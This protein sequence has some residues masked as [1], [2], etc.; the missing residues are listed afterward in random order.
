MAGITQTI[1][2][3]GGGG[4]SEQADQ[5]KLPG[6]LKECI[7]AIPDITYGLYKRPGAKRIGTTPIDTDSQ[8][9][10]WAASTAY[11]ST[12]TV[13]S[14]SGQ[15]TYRRA[16]NPVNTGLVFEVTTAGTSGSSEPT[17]PT[18]AGSTVTDGGVTWT[19]RKE[20]SWHHYY[21]DETEGSYIIFINLRGR[22]RVWSCNDASEKNVWFNTDNNAFDG[23]DA[24]DTAIRSYLESR[25]TEDKQ[26]LTI[27]D[28]TFITNRSKTVSTTGTTPAASDAHRA[29]IDLLRTENGR[30][31]GINIYTEETNQSTVNIA[32]RVRVSQ[33]NLNEGGGTAP[34]TGIGTQVFTVSANGHAE[35]VIA[36]SSVST[37]NDTITITGHG[38]ATGDVVTY[39]SNG[40]APGTGAESGTHQRMTPLDDC[41]EYFVIRTDAN[42]I[43]LAET[44]ANATAGTAINITNDGNDEQFI[45]TMPYPDIEV[46]N[47]AGNRVTT[48]KTNLVFRLTTNGQQGMI[49][50]RGPGY[51]SEPGGHDYQCSYRREITLLHGGEGWVTGDTVRVMM[52]T[53]GGIEPESSTSSSHTR[54]FRSPAYYVVTVEEHESVTVK[55]RVGSTTGAGLIR[56]APTPFD[57]DTAVTP[58]IILGGIQGAL[59]SAVTGTIIGNGI[60]LTSSNSFNVE[61]V[62]L[63]L[64]RVMQSEINDVSK[65]PI[66]C[67]DGFITKVANTEASE[68]DDY[69]VKFV[70]ENGRDGVGT[71]EECAAPGI[72]L[73]FNAST[74][75]HI[76]QRQ[77]DGD[78]LV[79]KYEWAD[80]EVGDDVTNEAPSFV[81]TKN[82]ADPPVYSQ[83]V[84]INK[85]LF[86]RNR[87]TFLS[88]T[89]V[90]TAQPGTI[91]KPNFWA[92]TAL[93]VSARD[94]VDIAC[95]SEYP[96]ALYDGIELPVGLLCFSSNQQ[97]LLSADDTVFNPDTAKLRSISTFNYNIVNPPLDLG[98]SVGYLDNTHKYSKFNELVNV[99][100]EGLPTIQEATKVVPSLLPKQ[101]DLTTNSR[102]NG[103]VFLSQSQSDT[104][105]VFKYFNTGE[106]RE[107][108]SWFKWKHNNPI[109]YHFAIEDTYYF[110]DTDGFLQSINLVQ[111]TND[112]SIDEGGVNFLLHFDNYTTITGGVY[113]ATTKLTTFTHGTGGCVFNWQSSVTSPNGDLALVDN[114]TTA[115]RVG[116]YAKPTVTSAGSTFTVPGDWSTGTFYIG[117]LYEY[118]V[119]FPR[120]YRIM[121]D[122]ERVRS[123]LNSSLI[124]HRMKLNLGKIGLYSTKLTRKGKS[125]YE[126]TYESSDLDEYDV[127]DAPYLSEKIKTIPVYE[128]NKN[129]LVTLTS[130]H[131]AP[132]TL[133]S[134]S[135]EGDLTQQNYRRV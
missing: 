124:V 91:A 120:F 8:F 128:N 68:E 129:V 109:K 10:A 108:S 78:F 26:T 56:P 51:G 117:Y 54:R 9:T 57:S 14:E 33:D 47:A 49:N 31:Y 107:Q 75:P 41:F 96:S 83:D 5:M 101:L 34:C 127:S 82:T 100:R 37:T 84:T 22:P 44:A 111:A 135:W 61:V 132:A 30:Q 77:A 15:I 25:D 50:G 86:Y 97:F 46:R 87:L 38:L 99:A 76:M 21:R 112:P 74:M 35:H 70:G 94:P 71:W 104:V 130:S 52:D 114:N 36:Q 20:G 53:A 28:T 39:R 62:D 110:L 27:N 116:R 19:A 93:T 13:D 122:G 67:K 58:D 80:R 98:M 121:V 45:T 63:D 23:S 118:N 90:I 115:T 133:H 72:V 88:D 113:S 123:D 60:Y 89:N 125:D 40:D 43:Q 105:Y 48:G 29:Y 64:M 6:Q 69:Y 79:K 119:Q 134:M 126:Q 102:E 55:A 16:V 3:Y 92:N 131:P 7:N 4:I 95:A 42:T 24:N 2:S 81:G 59:P 17:W 18:T 11:T 106:K 65:L 73:G 32:T 103:L 85:V 12:E 66:Q 1:P